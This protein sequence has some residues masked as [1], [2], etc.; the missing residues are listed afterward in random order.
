MKSYY[1]AKQ[2]EEQRQRAR[3]ESIFIAS[4]SIVICCVTGCEHGLATWHAPRM[5]RSSRVGVAV[6]RGVARRAT[7]LSTCR[8]DETI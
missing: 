4:M 6:R 8:A 5:P 1:E 2:A 7:L 3:Y